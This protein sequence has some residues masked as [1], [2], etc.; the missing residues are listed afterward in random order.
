LC[1]RW[2]RF[3]HGVQRYARIVPGALPLLFSLASAPVSP[4]AGIGPSLVRG[5]R[6]AGVPCASGGEDGSLA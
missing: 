4:G 2:L 6:Q 1:A 3:P 5:M